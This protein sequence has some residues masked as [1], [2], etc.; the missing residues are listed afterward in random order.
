MLELTGV[1]EP[2]PFFVRT[3]EQ[4]RY[5]GVRREGR[6]VAMAGERFRL[7]GFTEVSAVCTHPDVRGE[8]LGGALTLEISHG[9]RA[10]GDEAFLHLLATNETAHR[11]YLKLGFRDRRQNVVV[12]AQW[13]DDGL[14]WDAPRE[15]NDADAVA[16]LPHPGGPDR[17]RDDGAGA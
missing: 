12:A 15:T 10:R 3:H 13:H 1:T 11:L 14:A 17:P 7:P 4:G 8:G 16:A 2:G 9:I 6:L 5:V